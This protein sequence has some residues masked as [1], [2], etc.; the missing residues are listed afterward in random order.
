E[1]PRFYCDY[2]DA[3]LTHDS[4]TVRKQHNSGFKHKANVRNYYA[5]FNMIVPLHPTRVNLVHSAI[6]NCK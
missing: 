3:F 4:S 2:C 1:M 5:Q 6:T